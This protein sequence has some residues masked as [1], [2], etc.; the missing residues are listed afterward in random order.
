MEILGGTIGGGLCL[1]YYGQ[2]IKTQSLNEISKVVLIRR[3]LYEHV[4]FASNSY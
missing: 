2:Y 4:A 1:K 3:I